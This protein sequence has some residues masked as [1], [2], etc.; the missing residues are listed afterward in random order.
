MGLLF[1][2]INLPII[3][4]RLLLLKFFGGTDFSIEIDICGFIAVS[5]VSVSEQYAM[6]G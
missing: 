2:E 4:V 6:T 1:Y 3:T 5:V